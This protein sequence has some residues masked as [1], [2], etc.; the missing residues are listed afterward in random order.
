MTKPARVDRCVQLYE[1]MW[2]FIRD[3]HP[4]LALQMI[5][6][7]VTVVNVAP[8]VAWMRSNF[9]ALFYQDGNQRIYIESEEDVVLLTMKLSGQS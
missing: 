8:P 3:K 9:S 5:R 6:N 2:D 4:D 1:P 7:A